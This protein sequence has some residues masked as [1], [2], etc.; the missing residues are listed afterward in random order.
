[1]TSSNGSIFRV[2]GHLCGEFTGPRWLPHA[3]VVTQ[4]FNV[5]FVLHPNKLL[6][7]QSWGG[8]FETQSRPLWRHCNV[9]NGNAYTGKTSLYWVAPRG[10][11]TKA[12]LINFFVKRMLAFVT[13]PVR[14]FDSLSYLVGVTAAVLWWHLSYIDVVYNNLCF[15]NPENVGKQPNGTNSICNPHTL[16]VSNRWSVSEEVVHSVCSDHSG[17]S[18]VYLKHKSPTVSFFLH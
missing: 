17:R 6:S 18:F 9:Y 15:H 13:L 5:F 1:M 4:N 10:V 16:F 11:V 3:K 8:W 12:H 2:T 14:C 7:K